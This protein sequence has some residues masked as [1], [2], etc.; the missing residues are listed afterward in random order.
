[1]EVYSRAAAAALDP[2]SSARYY[3]GYLH[4]EAVGTSECFLAHGVAGIYNVVTLA[5]ARRRGVG[6]ALT[7]AALGAARSEGY[8]IAVLQASAAGQGIYARLGFVACG[9]FREYK[10]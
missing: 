7:S 5:H 1:M 8:Q 10:P 6:S 3:L 4:G 2:A 9:L